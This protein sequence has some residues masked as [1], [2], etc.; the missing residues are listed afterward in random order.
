MSHIWMSSLSALV[1]SWLT[2]ECVVSH[3]LI[4]S[5][6]WVRHSDFHVCIYIHI[7]NTDSFTDE[8]VSVPDSYEWGYISRCQTR[9]MAHWFS[10]HTHEW[11]SVPDSYEWG[12]VST[13]QTRLIHQWDM[14]ISV[15][16]KKNEW[17]VIHVTDHSSVRHV[18]H[19]KMSY[20]KYKSVLSQLLFWRRAFS[21]FCSFPGKIE[22]ACDW[23]FPA[24]N[25]EKAPR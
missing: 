20:H 25:K 12:Y 6:I 11:V 10:W 16:K 15:E 18:K 4:S 19:I 5:F 13:C 2:D 24:R 23:C 7:Y 9:L 21:R 3:M 14:K 17:Q 22:G 1:F 8:C